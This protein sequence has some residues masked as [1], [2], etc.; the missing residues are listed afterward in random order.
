M[1]ARYHVLARRIQLE[2]AELDRTQA[3]IQKH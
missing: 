2:I 3:A 1:I